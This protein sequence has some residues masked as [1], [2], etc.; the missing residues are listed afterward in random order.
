MLAYTPVVPKRVR[1]K[2][3][4]NT[5]PRSSRYPAQLNQYMPYYLSVEH[6]FKSGLSRP[7]DRE[8]HRC[9]YEAVRNQQKECHSYHL[10]P[11]RV[12]GTNNSRESCDRDRIRGEEI[13]SFSTGAGKGQI[14][15]QWRRRKRG[16]GGGGETI[17]PST[18][19]N[20]TSCGDGGVIPSQLSESSQRVD[21]AV[22]R[23]K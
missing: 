1:A 5:V 12:F 20:P 18:P 2:R 13:R 9:S 22:S 19:S 4:K 15:D 23:R 11:S 6:T 21:H 16:V 10:N 7:H 14:G 17:C 3:G 8:E